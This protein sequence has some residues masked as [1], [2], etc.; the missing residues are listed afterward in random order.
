[1]YVYSI[2]FVNWGIIYLSDT[3]LSVFEFNMLFHKQTK[4]S[5]VICVWVNIKKKFLTLTEN[6]E[7]Y[8]IENWLLN[9]I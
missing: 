6:M 3:C 5:N 1:M 2:I 8:V 7:N 4:I 9:C